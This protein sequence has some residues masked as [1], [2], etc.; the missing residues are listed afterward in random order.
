MVESVNFRLRSRACAF[1]GSRVCAGRLHRLDVVR[2]THP[3]T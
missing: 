1:A 2:F 3:I